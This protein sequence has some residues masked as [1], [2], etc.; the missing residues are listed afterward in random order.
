[1]TLVIAHPGSPVGE[2]LG[3]PDQPGLIDI[4]RGDVSVT[5]A[6]RQVPNMPGVWVITAGRHADHLDALLQADRVPALLTALRQSSSRVVIES[7]GIGEFAGAQNL[8]AESNAVILV[9]EQG[10]TKDALIKE[11]AESAADMG[12]PAVGVVIVPKVSA[13]KSGHPQAERPLSRYRQLPPTPVASRT[14]PK[15]E[16]RRP[17][18]SPR[19]LLSQQR[20]RAAL[21]GNVVLRSPR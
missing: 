21:T 7:L 9:A 5:Q 12:A 17:R 19:R 13:R 11:A 18:M 4:L 14:G 15:D 3:L 2:W 1:M 20:S 10:Q 8:A 6:R 16:P